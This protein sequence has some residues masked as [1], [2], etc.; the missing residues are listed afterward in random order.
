MEAYRTASQ[1]LDVGYVMG[2]YQDLG[3]A[4]TKK[5]DRLVRI[6]G[7]KPALRERIAKLFRLRRVAARKAGRNAG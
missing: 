2:A 7:Y 5:G 1:H 6:V 3:Y 4:Y